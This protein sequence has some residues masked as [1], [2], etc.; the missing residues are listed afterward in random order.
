MSKKKTPKKKIWVV[1]KIVKAATLE[2]A[3]KNEKRNKP[4]EIRQAVR[5]KDEL[6]SA[7]GFDASWNDYDDEEEY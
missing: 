5:S 1:R 4:V 7:I 2:E 6:A 3:L